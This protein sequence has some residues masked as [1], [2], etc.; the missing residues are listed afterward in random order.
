MMEHR[1]RNFPRSRS[2]KAPRSMKTSRMKLDIV[3]DKVVADWRGMKVEVPFKPGEVRKAMA[4]AE[5]LMLIEVEKY[6]SNRRKK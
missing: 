5:E 2:G 6:Y 1:E 3:G 4:R